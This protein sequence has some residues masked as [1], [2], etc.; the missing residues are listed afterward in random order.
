MSDKDLKQLFQK[1]FQ[2]ES[3]AFDPEAW[4]QAAQMLDDMDRK[5][6]VWWRLRWTP[7]L[8]LLLGAGGWW[9]W[10]S[11]T[12]NIAE[13]PTVATESTAPA[14]AGVAPPTKV[15]ASET[16]PSNTSGTSTIGSVEAPASTPQRAGSLPDLQQDTEDV[17]AIAPLAESTTDSPL[18]AEP[19]AR[20]PAAAMPA[21]SATGSVRSTSPAAT[22]V[23]VTPAS[24]ALPATALAKAAATT[25]MPEL[26][27]LSSQL[28]DV[29]SSTINYVQPD[30]ERLSLSPM[31]ALLYGATVE[32]PQ[33]SLATPKRPQ[34]I[35][36]PQQRLY[37]FAG[38]NGSQQLRP[39]ESTQS[40]IDY[41]LSAGVGYALRLHP[42]WYLHTD[43]AYTLQRGIEAQRTVEVIE[44]G[45]G[46]DRTRYTLAPQSLHF[47]ELPVYAQYHFGRH[48][49]L[50]GVQGAY[51]ANVRS[52]L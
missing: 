7:V 22:P 44:R 31:M 9:L 35:P 2:Q 3:F 5:R 40:G 43:L 21:T 17:E 13:A 29:P 14:T 16:V 11:S 12:E 49:V 47:V 4:D 45:F 18:A 50:V 24:A 34:L 46:L 19:E 38:W 20:T 10:P 52:Q 41:G 25:S 42:R 32:R 28:N 36:V 48:A 39:E 30:R 51:L 33:P 26:P 27:A 23:T 15:T 37:V 8:L 1:K 6:A